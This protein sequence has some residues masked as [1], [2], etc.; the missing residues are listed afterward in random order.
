MISDRNAEVQEEID[1]RTKDKYMYKR[2]EYLLCIATTA[3]SCLWG[4]KVDR[5]HEN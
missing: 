4:L 2:N 1:I 5:M 3:K